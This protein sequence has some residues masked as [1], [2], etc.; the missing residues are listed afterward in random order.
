[1]NPVADVGGPENPLPH[2]ADSLRVPRCLLDLPG[3]AADASPTC[4]LS[5]ALGMTGTA[6]GVRRAAR[7][8]VLRARRRLAR[9]SAGAPA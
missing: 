2:G 1:M 7:A 9:T 5:Q 6:S 8:R 3:R 4:V